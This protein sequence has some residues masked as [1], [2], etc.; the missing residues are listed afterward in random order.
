MTLPWAA[1]RPYVSLIV[2]ERIQDSD[3]LLAFQRLV[4]FLGQPGRQVPDRV[5]SV[6]ADSPADESAPSEVLAGVGFDQVAGFIRQHE[7]PPAWATPDVEFVDLQH[8]LTLAL[9][10]G[11]LVAVRAES[12]ITRRLQ[13]WLN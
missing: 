7:S 5:T 4:T 8:D 13:N 9:R 10:R 6:V 1:L 11:R 12:D 3:D 2:L